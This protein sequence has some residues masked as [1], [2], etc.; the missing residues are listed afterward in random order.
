MAVCYRQASDSL[1]PPGIQNGKHEGCPSLPCATVG[2]QPR[3]N[4]AADKATDGM[5]SFVLNL[6]G[7]VLFEQ[8]V[9]SQLIHS[10]PLCIYFSIR[11]LIIIT[12]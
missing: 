9:L 6:T 8:A 2:K 5:K 12:F 4:S 10:S 1:T 3:A 11:Q 7:T